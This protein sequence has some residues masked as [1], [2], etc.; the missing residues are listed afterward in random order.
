MKHWPDAVYRRSA[1]GRCS[2]RIPATVVRQALDAAPA[3]RTASA[4]GNADSWGR[5]LSPERWPGALTP[6]WP[7]SSPVWLLAVRHERA[8]P[9]A[10]GT[11]PLLG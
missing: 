2:V 11:I 7:F 10:T 5:R 9:A 8:R 4:G 1:I 3:R 6:V